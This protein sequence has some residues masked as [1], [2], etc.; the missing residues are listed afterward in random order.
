MKRIWL[1]EQE[2]QLMKFSINC[3]FYQIKCIVLSNICQMSLYRGNLLTERTLM[4]RISFFYRINTLILSHNNFIHSPTHNFINI[5]KYP[6]SGNSVH[7]KFMKL[8]LP[9]FWEWFIM[10]I[11][12]SE[13]KLKKYLLMPQ[14]TKF[15]FSYN[16]IP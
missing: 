8:K 13:H 4:D 2:Y 10:S 7:L 12:N 14:H 11:Y 9:N 6:S 1:S 5:S 16:F 3:R 15:L